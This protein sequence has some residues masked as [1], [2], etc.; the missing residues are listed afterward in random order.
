MDLKNKTS[1]LGIDGHS[2]YVSLRDYFACSI[3]N[4]MLSYA[5]FNP[6]D[7]DELESRVQLAYRTADKMLTL[8][9]NIDHASTNSTT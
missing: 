6:M 4:G 8:K 9:D 1:I 5:W 3:I 7:D 2:D